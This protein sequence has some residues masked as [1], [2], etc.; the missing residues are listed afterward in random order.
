MSGSGSRAQFSQLPMF[1]TAREIRS[2]YAPWEGD[3]E[4]NEHGHME[5]DEQMWARKRH[6]ASLGVEPTLDKQVM[7]EGVKNPI[8]LQHVD[9][10]WSGNAKPQLMGGQHRVAVMYEHR[11]DA[12]MPVEHFEDFGD[13]RRS[14]TTRE[15]SEI[16]AA[17]RRRRP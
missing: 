12:L 7:R 9:P 1:M 4:T 8:P 14:E 13:A 10:W 3:R 15:R 5:T 16:E 11:P 6:E 17:A 2:Q